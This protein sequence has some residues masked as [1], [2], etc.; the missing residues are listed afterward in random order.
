[1][2]AR[3]AAIDASAVTLSGLCLIHCMA[4]PLLA[5]FLPVAGVFA[6]A[7]WVHKAFV[8]AALP[9]S[10][11]AIVR[12]WKSR[13]GTGFTL[14]AILGLTLL[15]SAAFVPALHAYETPLT[16]TGVV[17]TGGG[18]LWP[19]LFAVTNGGL[20]TRFRL[21]VVLRFA[22]ETFLRARGLCLP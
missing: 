5:A 11:F 2:T 18:W 12:S 8:A 6:E 20:S 17:C 7:E 10:G 3:A 14:L 4:L 21:R 9:V 15:V 1:M 16:V 19:P 13:G 22:V